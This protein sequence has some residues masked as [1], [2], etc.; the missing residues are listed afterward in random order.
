M[1]YMG[2]DYGSK[3]TGVALS[4]E[5]GFMAFPKAVYPTDEDLLDTLVVLVRGENVEA[6]V[7]GESRNYAGNENTLMLSAR[8]LAADLSKETACPVYFESEILTTKEAER[9]QGSTPMTDAS[10]AAIILQSYI[11]RDHHHGGQ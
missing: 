3:K 10:A 9:L 8:A 1:R 5:R 2:I 7:M 4:D 11:D 6:I